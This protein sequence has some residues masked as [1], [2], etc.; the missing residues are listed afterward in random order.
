[1]KVVDVGRLVVPRSLLDSRATARV[2]VSVRGSQLRLI[3]LLR[4]PSV[5]RLSLEVAELLASGVTLRTASS[6]KLI[7][8]E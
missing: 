8:R 1:M 6:S 7:V 5:L 4:R 2:S 3:S